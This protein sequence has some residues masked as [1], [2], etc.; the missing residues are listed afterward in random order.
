[1]ARYWKYNSDCTSE[2]VFVGNVELRP[3]NPGSKRPYS[4]NYAFS[5]RPRVLAYNAL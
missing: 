3:K 5:P 1:M 4:S 2:I